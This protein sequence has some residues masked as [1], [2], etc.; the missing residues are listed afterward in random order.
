MEIMLKTKFLNLPGVGET[1]AWHHPQKSASLTW[2]CLLYEGIKV[3]LCAF[4]RP[5]PEL[6]I[7]EMMVRKRWC[8]ELINKRSNTTKTGEG[9]QS[10]DAA[11]G[12]CR[13][14]VRDF[15]EANGTGMVMWKNPWGRIAVGAIPG[16]WNRMH[17][18]SLISIQGADADYGHG[19]VS[20]RTTTV[21][22][23]Y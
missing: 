9:E 14:F 10:D 2:I 17:D 19:R 1:R 5:D 20:C 22:F 23:F 21:S 3:L 11:A 4:G 15:W 8:M 12:K 6:N 13:G 18:D 7:G 16:W